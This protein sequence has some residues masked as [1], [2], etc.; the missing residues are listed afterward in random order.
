MRKKPPRRDDVPRFTSEPT[1]KPPRESR[2]SLSRTSEEPPS[3][4]S[5]SPRETPP[6]PYPRAQAFLPM[7]SF[8]R[9]A[10]VLKEHDV[11][12]RRRLK[13]QVLAGRI[14]DLRQCAF[15]SEET[16]NREPNT[17]SFH[18]FFFSIKGP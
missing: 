10:K 14:E 8:L 12:Q 4:K 15:T 6:R 7:Q 13:S 17:D 3:V 5:T 2:N 1:R 11:F 18:F 9:V 16:Q